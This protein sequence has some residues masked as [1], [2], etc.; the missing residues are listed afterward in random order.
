[1]A[2]RFVSRVE[3]ASDLKAG[4]GG[5]RKLQSNNTCFRLPEL[6]EQANLESDLCLRE[7]DIGQEQTIK[8]KVSTMAP[9]R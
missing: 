3:S 1:V 6:I 2:I 8:N 5:R 7:P 4:G 9:A